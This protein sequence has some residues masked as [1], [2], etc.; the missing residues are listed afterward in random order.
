MKSRLLILGLLATLLTGCSLD[1]DRDECCYDAILYFH[2]TVNGVDQF[3]RDIS[4]LRHFVYDTN[5][6]FYSE[7][8]SDSGDLQ[9]LML[10][11]LPEGEYTVITI[12]NASDEHTQI[13]EGRT[14]E[15]LKVL[16]AGKQADDSYANADQLFWNMQKLRI[17]K[18][19]QR[20]ILCAL[21]NIHCHLHVY[22]KWR[23]LPHYVGNFTMRLYDVP[24]DYLAGSYY[25]MTRNSV[26]YF[27]VETKRLVEHSKEVSPYN[28][29]LDGELIT[30]RWSDESIPALQIFNGSES[31]TGL[32]PLERAFSEWM[33]YPSRQPIQDYS[34]KVEI[35][36]QGTAY[37]N[38]WTPGEILDWEDGGII[39]R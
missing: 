17:V 32:I 27:P 30:H 38:R 20:T 39:G 21:S 13:V 37:V 8:E 15:E 2:E 28:F 11:G 34:I 19:E 26:Y 29:E 25:T 1:D 9:R 36:D 31:V 3:K 24:A 12:A 35:D 5:D 23:S 7:V 16:M 4:S 22:V 10:N 33:W 14:I 18:N 6:N